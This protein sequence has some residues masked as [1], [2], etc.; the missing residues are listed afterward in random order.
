MFKKGENMEWHL[1]KWCNFACASS[2]S[3][4]TS[5]KGLLWNKKRKKQKTIQEERYDSIVEDENTR[6]EIVCNPFYLTPNLI[7]FRQN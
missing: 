6:G 2:D 1:G 5:F 3:T 7:K 4:N